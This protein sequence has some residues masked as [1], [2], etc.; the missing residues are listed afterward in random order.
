[1]D[2]VDRVAAAALEAERVR[3]EVVEGG[4]VVEVDGLVV[5]LTNLPA[6]ELNGTRVAHEPAD[7]DAALERARDVFRSRGH[8]FFGIEIEVGR[9]PRIEAAIRAAGLRRVEAWPAMAVAIAGVPAVTDP[10]GVEIRSVDGPDGLAVVRAMETAVFGTPPAV[11]ERFIGDAIVADDRVATFVARVDDEP[12]GTS[13]GYLVHGTRRDLR[14]GCRGERAAPRDRRRAHGSG[15][16]RV[17]GPCRRRV[18]PAVRRRARPV[19][20]PRIRDRV[21]VG[22]LDRRR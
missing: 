20:R 12:V 10:S 5:T 6:P 19:P 16:P 7:P 1:M 3:T 9:H 4:E 2:V 8:P 15:C 14:R 21:A 13:T 18:A 11:A 22:G 17:P